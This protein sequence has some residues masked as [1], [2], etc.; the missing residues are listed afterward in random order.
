MF[1]YYF[2]V[3]NKVLWEE[4]KSRRDSQRNAPISTSLQGFAF[5][6]LILRVT[7]HRGADR[8]KKPR[9]TS[10]GLT[11][12]AKPPSVARRRVLLPSTRGVFLWIFEAVLLQR[13]MDVATATAEHAGTT[14]KDELAEKCQK[15]FQ[16]FLE[17]WV[18]SIHPAGGVFVVGLDKSITSWSP[19]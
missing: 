17:E 19:A 8:T 10:R 3:L 16:A 11:F 4:K 14:V 18:S 1:L 12:R 5:N 7:P 9:Q 2:L 15:L 6:W 13:R